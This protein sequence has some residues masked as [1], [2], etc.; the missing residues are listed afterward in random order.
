MPPGGADDRRT[1][2]PAGSDATASLRPI[3]PTA[4]CCWATS[5]SDAVLLARRG[6]EIFAIGA[7]CT[8]YGG[9]LAEGL[10]VGDTVRCPW[11]HACFSL[12]TG[13]ALRAPA[14]EPSPV[15]ARRAA[16]RP[17]VRAGQA[18]EPDAQRRARRDGR[19]AGADRHRRR[20]RGRQRRGRD[21]AARGLRRAA[22]RCSAPT[23]RRPSTG[24]TCRR[25]ISPA[26]RPRMDPAA[27]AEFY[28]EQRIELR[29]GTRGRPRSIAGARR[30]RSRTASTHALRRAAA[31]HRRRAG[32]AADSRRRLA[33]RP[34]PAHAR[35]QPRD[36]RARRDGASARSSIG[37]SFIGL[38]VA[39]SLRA[40]EL[41][42]HVVAP[43]ARPLER[44]LGPELGDF[45]RALHE[46][47]GVVF[48]LGRHA[49]RDRARSA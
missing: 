40:R 45:V 24:R 8:H 19:R 39:A 17:V 9:P 10:L 47:H 11:H 49:D 12:R 6:D 1:S 22:S 16:R 4:A 20:R 38:E 32:P 37:A 36:H 33:A 46:E 2:R 3:S 34:L 21:A 41:E 48:H 13:E 26:P 25:T 31:R 18:S 14:L 35:R 5:A 44:V 23:T 27:P 29:L 42:V 15:L 30:S 7:T 43:E 28:A